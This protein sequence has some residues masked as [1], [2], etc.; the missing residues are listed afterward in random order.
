MPLGKRRGSGAFGNSEAAN[1]RRRSLLAL[2][3]AQSQELLT[4]VVQAAS[5]YMQAGLQATAEGQQAAAAE[6]HAAVRAAL[7]ALAALAG[8]LP[9]KILNDSQVLDACASLVQ[10]PELQILAIEVILQVRVLLGAAW[11]LCLPQQ[12]A[13]ASVASG[14]RPPGHPP[15]RMQVASRSSKQSSK[16]KGDYRDLFVRVAQFLVAC[17]PLLLPPDAPLDRVLEQ[18]DAADGACRLCDALVDLVLA[19]HLPGLSRDLQLQVSAPSAT[20]RHRF[21]H[22]PQP[23]IVWELLPH[24][25]L[26]GPDRILLVSDRSA[27]YTRHRSCTFLHASIA[28]QCHRN[29]VNGWMDGTVGTSV[30]SSGPV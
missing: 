3:T 27:V 18:E 1:K 2:M 25:P 7:E 17:V 5:V 10:A 12:C 11:H 19:G 9:L 30:G 13:H 6:N 16:E 22:L 21:S 26:H 15:P 23:G 28:Y 24:K 4:L 14:Q 20:T 29:T 8:W